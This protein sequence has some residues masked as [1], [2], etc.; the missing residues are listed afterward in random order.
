MKTYLANLRR[1][2]T[3][4]HRFSGRETVDQ[5]W[6]WA[7]TVLFALF[8]GF[9]LAGRFVLSDWFA[10]VERIARENPELVT[11]SVGPG[12]Y[13]VR[14]EGHHPELVPALLPFITLAAAFGVIAILLLGAAL[15]RRLHDSG[16]T[17]LWALLPIP[18]LLA[19]FWLMPQLFRSWATVPDFQLFF[20][21][22]ANNVVY[23]ATIALLVFFTTR[24]GTPGPN[25]YGPP[26][27]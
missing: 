27:A 14:V 11:R 3:S 19:G 22:F 6:A 8:V 26:S 18:F 2:L 7:G 1:H 16:R 21:L 4:L 17:G 25:R 12:H 9:S 15:T 5:F 20:L 10:G 23:L 13:S 24:N